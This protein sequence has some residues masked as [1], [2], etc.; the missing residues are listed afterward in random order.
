MNDIFLNI[1]LTISALGNLLIGRKKSIRCFLFDLL[2][3]FLGVDD[4]HIYN[5]LQFSVFNV[6]L[7]F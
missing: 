3:I 2:L 6:L 7:Y 4:L 5:I 1:V